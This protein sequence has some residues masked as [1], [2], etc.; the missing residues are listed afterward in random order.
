M[1][2]RNHS[3][4]VRNE[5]KWYLGCAYLKLPNSGVLHA[6]A[7]T[8]L[9]SEYVGDWLLV[10]RLGAGNG[11]WCVF[12]GRMAFLCVQI[13]GRWET[14]PDWANLNG[15]CLCALSREIYAENKIKLLL[16]KIC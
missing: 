1:E 15:A 11:G 6:T 14:G 16:R 3:P 12:L 7:L 8:K 5:G 10:C 4:F 2:G 9:W 13:T